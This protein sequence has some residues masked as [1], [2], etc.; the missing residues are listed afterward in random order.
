MDD[1]ETDGAEGHH[2]FSAE[3]IDDSHADEGEDH[4]GETDDDEVE[5]DAIDGESGIAEDVWCVVED[6]V[7]AAPLLEDGDEDAQREDGEHLGF[8]NLA[9][10]D[11]FVV[12]I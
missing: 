4:V 1:E 2:G 7:D 11:L 6:D 5:H 12:F 9:D 8:E 10:A 3:F